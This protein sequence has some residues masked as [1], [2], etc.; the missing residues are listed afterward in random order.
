ML[1]RWEQLPTD[2]GCKVQEVET[3]L[4]PGAFHSSKDA[5][6]IHQSKPTAC[7]MHMLKSWLGDYK[8][9]GDQRS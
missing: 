7:F 8:V 1:H 2:H 3:S 4:P 5:Q 6:K 9:W